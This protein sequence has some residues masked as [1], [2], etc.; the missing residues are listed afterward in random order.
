MTT[1]LSDIADKHEFDDIEDDREDFVM[2]RFK[3]QK[4]TGGGGPPP[5][6]DGQAGGTPIY[7]GGG[8]GSDANQTPYTPQKKYMR[9]KITIDFPGVE[10]YDLDD[11]SNVFH[12]LYTAREHI[13]NNTNLGFESVNI[14]V[15]LDSRY[16]TEA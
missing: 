9:A 7:V 3:E 5:D 15:E 1:K 6:V 16:I 2:S 11:Y 8:G 12:I 10:E 13:V 4:Y 14:N